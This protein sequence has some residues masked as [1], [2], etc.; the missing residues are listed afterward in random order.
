MTLHLPKILRICIVLRVWA[1][2]PPRVPV[3]SDSR[4]QS[5]VGP[6][7][8]LVPEVVEPEYLFR[9]LETRRVPSSDCYRLQFEGGRVVF[10]RISTFIYLGIFVFVT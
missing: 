5:G 3:P 9:T 1:C 10:L 2:D 4:S 8:S 7:W 6:V